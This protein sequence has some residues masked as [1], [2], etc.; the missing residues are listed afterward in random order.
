MKKRPFVL[1]R[2]KDR[3]GLPRYHPASVPMGPGARDRC[4]GRTRSGLARRRCLRVHLD[5]SPATFGAVLREGLSAGGPSSLASES[6][7][8]DA[9]AY[10]SGSTSEC[11]MRLRRQ[12]T[13]RV[14]GCQR[15]GARREP[16]VWASTF[17]SRY[18]SEPVLHALH[19]ALNVPQ[20]GERLAARREI[21]DRQDH[22]GHVADDRGQEATIALLPAQVIIYPPANG[23]QNNERL[24]EDRE[25]HRRP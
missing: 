16:T 5:D 12:G 23:V 18:R 7:A 15:G 17:D 24:E 6:L 11:G 8:S 19:S 22:R 9:R 13:M 2:T 10:S 21:E 4:N 20:R 1:A 3:V 14:G 25:R